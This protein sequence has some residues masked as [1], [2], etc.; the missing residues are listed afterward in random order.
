MTN[1]IYEASGM[2]YTKLPYKWYQIFRKKKYE[3]TKDYVV[4]LPRT[5]F[6]DTRIFKPVGAGDFD[7][8]HFNLVWSTVHKIFRFTI[9]KGYQHNACNVIPDTDNNYKAGCIHDALSELIAMEI[10]DFEYF[11]NVDKYFKLTLMLNG[12]WAWLSWCYFKAV[13]NRLV[14][15]WSKSK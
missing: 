8:K 7:N 6:P 4:Y 2:Y 11:D 3:Q 1:K 15:S 12:V 5:L 13:N 9:K 10:I 14:H